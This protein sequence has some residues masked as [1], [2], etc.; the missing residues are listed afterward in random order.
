MVC[1]DI[2]KHSY[3]WDTFVFT[4]LQA[5]NYSIS[6]LKNSDSFNSLKKKGRFY[7]NDISNRYGD[8]DNISK[9]FS[10]Q[11]PSYYTSYSSYYYFNRSNTSRLHFENTGNFSKSTYTVNVNFLTGFSESDLSSNG[12]YATDTSDY[13]FFCYQDK[14]KGRAYSDIWFP[15][16]RTLV[17]DKDSDSF[18]LK[19]IDVFYIDKESQ[20]RIDI[21]GNPVSGNWVNSVWVPDEV[22]ID[23]NNDNNNSNCGK[24]VDG[25]WVATDPKPTGCED[26]TGDDGANVGSGGG[27]GA[28][29]GDDT[30]NEDYEFAELFDKRGI[31]EYDLEMKLPKG[32]PKWVNGAVNGIKV[33]GIEIGLVPFIEYVFSTIG[34]FFSYVFQTVPFFD[35]LLNIW[36]MPSGT[37]VN[38]PN[39]ILGSGISLQGLFGS[40]V[41]V[42]YSK[43][44]EFSELIRILV[45]LSALFSAIKLFFSNFF[46]K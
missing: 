3:F 10:K 28:A 8:N 15:V 22:N 41:V 23:D 12:F 36:G 29:W 31:F 25:V 27:G 4:D 2:P 34:T 11:A 5:L 20:Q 35:D 6:N 13:R 7:K 42:N 24:W 46:K 21:D 18:D 26:P 16:P 1:F 17:Y 40:S 9:N 43:N 19:V 38:V 14:S 32:T 30:T 45:M 39:N 44:A 37:V 33:L